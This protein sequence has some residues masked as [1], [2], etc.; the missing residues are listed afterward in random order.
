MTEIT[1]KLSDE[2]L[3]QLHEEME[4]LDLPLESVIQKALADYLYVEPTDAEILADLHEA[5]KNALAGN[6]RPARELL[7]D[8][9]EEL[10]EDADPS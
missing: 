6:T 1:L 3:A 9:D 4:R 5:M 2:M 7:A 10:G 8:L